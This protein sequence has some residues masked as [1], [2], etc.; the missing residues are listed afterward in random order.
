MAVDRNRSS[1]DG[2]ARDG[3][4]PAAR[5]LFAELIGTFTLVFVDAG[6]DVVNAISGGRST[7]SRGSS[8]RRSS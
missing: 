3:E 7:S 5:R 8:R 4:A 1:A 2:A 6:A